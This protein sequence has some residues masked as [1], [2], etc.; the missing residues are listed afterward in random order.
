MKTVSSRE[1]NRDVGGAKRAASNE[2]VFITDRGE[3]SHVLL[4]IE[5]FRSL[6]ATGESALQEAER[7]SEACP[8]D[9][10]WEPP[11]LM[12]GSAKSADFGE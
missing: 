6:T 5:H 12:T 9:F 2:P 1:F 4:S 11:R 7:I 10:D 8:T 3:P